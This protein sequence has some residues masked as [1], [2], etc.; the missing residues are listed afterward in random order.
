MAEYTADKLAADSGR[1]EEAGDGRKGG[2]EEGGAEAAPEAASSAE[3]RCSNLDTTIHH[4]SS[5]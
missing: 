5:V 3:G 4:H 2:G 1:R